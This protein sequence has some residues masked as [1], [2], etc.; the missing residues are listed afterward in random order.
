VTD[1]GPQTYATR[2]E[3]ASPGRGEDRL[4]VVR[5]PDRTV[6][7]VAD[8]AGGVVGGVA[9][10]EA[11]CDGVVEQ[12]KRGSP[13]SWAEWL[14]QLDRHMPRAGLAAA[15]VV[16]LADDGRIVGASAGDCEAWLFGNGAATQLTAKQSFKPLLGEGK[17][18]PVAFAADGAGVLVVATDGLW[19]YVQRM[20]IAEAVALRPLVAAADALVHGARLKSG[21]LSDDVALVI[22]EVSVDGT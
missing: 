4:A 17:A 1:A 7:V 14:V 6:F 13:R 20:R 9:A 10:A 3:E 12:C 11:V 19:K 21:R 16:E 22:C 2:I 15:V 5:L 18:I 8:G